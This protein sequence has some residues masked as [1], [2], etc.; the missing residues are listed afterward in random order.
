M[1]ND[2]FD[3]WLTRLEHRRTHSIF[4]VE[5]LAIFTIAWLFWVL[6][7]EWAPGSIPPGLAA[8]LVSG[9]Y[10]TCLIYG[11]VLR[12]TGCRKCNNPMPFL[13][14]E[15][16]RWHLPD[17]EECIEL[18]YGG[19]EWDRHFVHVYCKVARADIVAYRCRKCDQLWEEK[20]ELPGSGYKLVRRTEM[21]K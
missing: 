14:R 18:D 9:L 1:P 8:T 15:V 13:R 7:F 21:K 4:L 2:L 3:R 17:H 10:A 6:M 12:V 5:W 16:G 19:D 20:I 11:R